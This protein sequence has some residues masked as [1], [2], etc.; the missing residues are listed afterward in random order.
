MNFAASHDNRRY[1][2]GVAAF[3]EDQQDV[4]SLLF[5]CELTS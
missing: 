1:F 2:L 4:A 5:D 3:A